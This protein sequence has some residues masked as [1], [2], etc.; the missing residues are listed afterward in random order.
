MIN[1]N[2]KMKPSVCT[3]QM[4]RT[5]EHTSS[6]GCAL[7]CHAANS[8]MAFSTPHLRK[9]VCHVSSRQV[10][11]YVGWQW[12]NWEKPRQTPRVLSWTL[13]GYCKMLLK[14]LYQMTSVRVPVPEKHIG[15]SSS[16]HWTTPRVYSTLSEKESRFPTTGGVSSDIVANNGRYTI[17]Y[18][19][20]FHAAPNAKTTRQAAAVL[21]M[22]QSDLVTWG[23]FSSCATSA[24]RQNKHRSLLQMTE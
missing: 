15:Q 23:F 1:N 17:P 19:I 21:P 10:A 20:P 13:G 14:S 11:L 16:V 18:P 4:V 22:D 8:S 2:T 6:M 9:G 5:L 7:R 12:R 3:F 24:G